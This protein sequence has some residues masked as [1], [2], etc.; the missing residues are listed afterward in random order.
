MPPRHGKDCLLHAW[1]LDG[2]AGQ[3]FGAQTAGGALASFPANVVAY[4][5]PAGAFAFM[6][7]GVLALGIVRDSVLNAAN[8]HMVFS[9]SFE[10]VLHR[11]GEALRLTVPVTASGISRAAA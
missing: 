10:A 4:V 11:A 9:E 6:D 5:F 3:A 1:T 8:D 2:E 7:G